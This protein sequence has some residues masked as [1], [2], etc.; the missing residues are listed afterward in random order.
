MHGH[1]P[2]GESACWV[3]C[4]KVFICFPKAGILG[5]DLNR[6]SISFMLMCQNEIYSLNFTCPSVWLANG[7]NWISAICLPE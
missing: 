3:L 7:I 1:V 2:E 4:L 5:E 6:T